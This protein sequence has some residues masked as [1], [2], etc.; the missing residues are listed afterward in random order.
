VNPPATRPAGIDTAPSEYA[1]FY[2]AL[3]WWFERMTTVPAPLQEKMT[4]FWHGHFACSNVKVQ[5]W[6]K[7]MDQNLLFRSLGVGSFR[8]LCLQASLS[9]AML[10]YL[11]NIANVAANPQENFARE[12]MEL[13][14]IGVGEF[15]ESDVVAMTRAWTGHGQVGWNGTRMDFD[16][17]FRPEQ[18]DNGLKTLFGITRNWD[19]P[20]TID[21]LVL[22]VKRTACARFI[23]RK[24]YRFFVAPQAPDAVVNALA[25]V[26]ET[27]GMSIGALLRAMFLHE[28]FWASENRFAL[29][30]SP[31][32]YV[33]NLI[34][35]TGLHLADAGLHFTLYGMGQVPFY[36][37]NVD[38]WPHHEGW[39]SSST[40]W[41]RA[42]FLQFVQ[43]GTAG[44]GWWGNI[45]ALG[46]DA[47]I[48]KVLLDLGLVDASP[49]T[50]SLLKAWFA[51]FVTQH[52]WAAP[53]D[54]LLMGCM[55][56]E[57]QLA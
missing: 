20:D 7:M 47:G 1:G 15:T 22:G 12:L 14:T 19:A 23:T 37:P 34:R 21:E 6:A 26:F 53:A 48:D 51:D 46:A 2:S 45:Q 41:A 57:F 43:W 56:P 29:V 8:D 44:N 17:L 24:L 31:I 25:T 5:T 42:S 49:A 50:V 18:H 35:V 55:T 52:A 27:S 38:G 10:I 30:R 28:S 4:L 33:V 13:H 40:L 54:C 9:P 32:E 3:Y 11:D 16:Y 36:P 39:L